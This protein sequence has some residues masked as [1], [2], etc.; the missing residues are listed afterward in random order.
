[1]CAHVRGGLCP[2]PEAA[3]EGVPGAAGGVSEC[4]VACGGPQVAWGSR[5]CWRG[6][7]CVSPNALGVGSRGGTRATAPPPSPTGPRPGRAA[8]SPG[9]SV[10]SPTN[11][12]RRPQREGRAASGGKGFLR[13]PGS[14]ITVVPAVVTVSFSSFP[15]LVY[16]NGGAP[17]PTYRT[18]AQGPGPSTCRSGQPGP[19]PRHRLQPPPCHTHP[20]TPHPSPRLTHRRSLSGSSQSFRFPCE[21]N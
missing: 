8:S 19:L 13:T 20:P 9:T 15:S 6:C 3:C 5:A 1:M 2:G 4:A 14:F 12:P 16:A 10:S 17:P 18:Q 7:I 21:S 11:G